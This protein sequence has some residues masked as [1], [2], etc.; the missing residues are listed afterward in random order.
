MRAAKGQ[1]RARDTALRASTWQRQRNP[2]WS[3]AANTSFRACGPVTR[4]P[5]AWFHGDLASGEGH[6]E[7]GGLQ[8]AGLRR[9]SGTCVL[10]QGQARRPQGDGRLTLVWDG[11]VLLLQEAGDGSGKHRVVDDGKRGQKRGLVVGDKVSGN[12]A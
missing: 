12:V 11:R 4:K 6:R 9:S 3:L 10:C 7:K 5:S 2:P 1:T 8:H